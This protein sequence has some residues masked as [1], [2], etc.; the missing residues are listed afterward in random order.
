[1]QYTS[2]QANKLLKK[3]NEERERLL[4]LERAGKVFIA[5]TTEDKE[6]ARPEYSYKDTKK[7]LAKIEAD[8]RVIKHAINVFNTTHFVEDFD[9]TVDQMLIYIPQLVERKYQLSQMAQALPKQRLTSN[10]RTNLIEYQF[11]NYDIDII[12]QDY[13][14][15]SEEL[16]RAQV[17]LDCLNNTETFSFSIE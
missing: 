2:A 8:I 12:K 16:S 13:A 5:A 10:G 3:L 7:A 14:A 1:M 15:I 17:A 11:V 4:S 6:S 9:L